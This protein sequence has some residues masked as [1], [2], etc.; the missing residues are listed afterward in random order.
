MQELNSADVSPSRSGAAPARDQPPL[1]TLTVVP[2]Q[3]HGRDFYDTSSP[4]TKLV[5]IRFIL[6]IA[7]ANGWPL[8]QLDVNKAFL[9]GTL[10]EEVYM[11]QP[12]GF[13][14]PDY[15]HHIWKLGKAIY[16]LKQAPQAWYLE[17]GSF[18]LQYR[19]QKST[20]DASLFIYNNEGIISYFLVYVD[21]IFLTGNNETFLATFIKQ[22][23]PR[24]TSW[25]LKLSPCHLQHH[26][27]DVYPAK[28]VSK[29]STE[30]KYKALS[31]VALEVIWGLSLIARTRH[32]PEIPGPT[33]FCDNTRVNY[34]CTNPVYHSHMKHVVLEYHFVRECAADGS[35]CVRHINS[36]TCSQNLLVVHSSYISSP[37]LVSPMEPPSC[38]GRIKT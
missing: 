32:P 7:L 38:G 29:S 17:L 12:P 31:H 9:H 37:R 26:L 35:L 15:P 11:T 19:F 3:E 27:L 18:L 25:E 13:V 21:D 23:A 10:N 30:A 33:L 8:R 22:L 20:T 28:L 6:C 1:P 34:L 2:F 5:T 16:G 24:I 36:L 14:H 4:V